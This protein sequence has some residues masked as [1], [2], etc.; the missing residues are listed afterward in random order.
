MK[1]FFLLI[2]LLLAALPASA[3]EKVI[4]LDE[5]V[6]TAT[7]TEEDIYKISSNVT[8]I[9]QEDIK[10]SPATT[11]QN[12]LKNEEGVI[13]NDLYGTGTKSIVD[14]R[15]FAYGADTVILIDGRRINEVDTGSVDWNLIPIENVER[16]EIV[17]GTE[18]VLYGDNAVAGAINIITK[19]GVRLPELV[20]HA[21]A[22]SYGGHAEYATFQG[23]NDKIGYFFFLTPYFYK[24]YNYFEIAELASNPIGILA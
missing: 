1:Q 23:A 13:I 16:I 6:V 4:S 19:K 2:M 14:M 10:K 22:E 8:V 17:R 18:S 7:R 9:T 3:E 12:L 21:R 15:G 11:V 24:S 5:V 20:L